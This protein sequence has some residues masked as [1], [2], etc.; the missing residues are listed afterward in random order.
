VAGDDAALYNALLLTVED[1]AQLKGRKAIVVFSNGPDNASSVP[2]EDVAELAQST[3]TI[4]YIISTRQAQ[5]EPVSAA[6]FERMSRATGGKAYF[7]GNWRE[8]HDAFS[9]IRDDL[10][11]LY[12]LSYYP[13]A[14]PNHGWRSIHVELNGRDLQ[15]Y[16]I[17]TRD[18]Y[19]L[20][21][22]VEVNDASNAT[23]N[24]NVG[25]TSGDASAD[26]APSAAAP[27]N[28]APANPAPADATPAKGADP[29][30][31]PA[32]NPAA[33]PAASPAA[34]PAADPK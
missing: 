19:R 31:S 1:A 34:N 4:I 3:G 12:T 32:A 7:A 33:D 23:S 25:A 13:Q 27:A 20:L 18:G 8:E 9:S 15:K 21:Q 26:P 24:G 30:A 22:H 14:N 29:A 11:H 2:P 17:R 10:G 5:A 28:P 6:A 16:H